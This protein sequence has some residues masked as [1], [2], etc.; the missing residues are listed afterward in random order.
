MFVHV[1]SPCVQGIGE[2]G[3]VAGQ[4]YAVWRA[5]NEERIALLDLKLLQECSAEDDAVGVT[6]LADLYGL[7]HGVSIAY[8][9]T[10][11]IR[12]VCIARD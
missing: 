1:S 10:D 9:I 11:V 5:H 12:V 4:S 3:I 7:A 2:I 6:D 8:V